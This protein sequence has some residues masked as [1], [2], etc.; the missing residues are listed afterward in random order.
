MPDIWERYIA[1][2]TPTSGNIKDYYGSLLTDEYVPDVICGQKVIEARKEGDPLE[3]TAF[4]STWWRADL[5]SRISCEPTGDRDIV[6]SAV[7]LIK[8]P[9]QWNNRLEL[10]KQYILSGEEA[11]QGKSPFLLA[12]IGTI[13]GDELAAVIWTHHKVPMPMTKALYSYYPREQADG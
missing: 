1:E 4:F 2:E 9:P 10:L 5:P 12:T 13:K 3:Y 7:D 6:F 11:A 8:R